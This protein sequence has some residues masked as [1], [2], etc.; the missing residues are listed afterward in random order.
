MDHNF[1]IET[2]ENLIRELDSR[3]SEFKRAS[4]DESRP[5]PT[6]LYLFFND[7][8]RRELI[9]E[10]EQIKQVFRRGAVLSAHQKDIL[11]YLHLYFSFSYTNSGSGE[12]KLRK[13]RVFY[14]INNGPDIR[15]VVNHEKVC[16]P[17][18]S[19]MRTKDWVF[20]TTW[21]PGPFPVLAKQKAE[22]IEEYDI[23]E[24]GR[25]IREHN[26]AP[27][28]EV[29]VAEKNYEVPRVRSDVKTYNRQKEH[30]KRRI[31]LSIMQRLSGGLFD[32]KYA[33]F[34]DL[35]S[36]FSESI[37][38]DV[39]TDDH[40]YILAFTSTSKGLFF[41]TSRKAAQAKAIQNIPLLL[42]RGCEFASFNHAANLI[43][44][45]KP[46]KIEKQGSSWYITQKAIISLK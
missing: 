40:L 28:P 15:E 9:S 33:Y 13:K 7:K 24:V 20:T 8:F 41:I 31:R 38:K 29:K 11:Q 37:L 25:F 3:Q 45:L 18:T 14:R 30:Y 22:P 46:G 27:G 1:T 44:T 17:G 6:N 4:I 2:V 21:E 34:V 42:E 5:E 36:G 10:L 43:I 16:K 35:P 26:P 32:K 39:Q 23:V 19:N 12:S